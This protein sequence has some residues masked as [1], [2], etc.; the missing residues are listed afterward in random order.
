MGVVRGCWGCGNGVAGRSRT[1]DRGGW[2]EL[3]VCRIV[4][5]S[6]LNVHICS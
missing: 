4:P 5:P 2:D 6:P 1:T 3:K